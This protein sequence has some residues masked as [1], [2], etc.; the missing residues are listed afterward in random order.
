MADSAFFDLI[1][2]NG[3]AAV[4]LFMLFKMS[5]TLKDVF[6]TLERIKYLEVRLEKLE[7]DVQELRFILRKVDTNG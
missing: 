3:I 1:S 4:S 2:S 6:A 7:K 5:N